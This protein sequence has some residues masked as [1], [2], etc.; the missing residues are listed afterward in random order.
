MENPTH[1]GQF[2]K[3]MANDRQAK[4]RALGI[5]GTAKRCKYRNVEA[6]FDFV[7]QGQKTRFRICSVPNKDDSLS[8]QH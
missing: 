2:R 4:A 3:S 1:R 8:L 7:N 6:E 5:V